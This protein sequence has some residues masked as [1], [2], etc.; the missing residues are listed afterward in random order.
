MDGIE[1]KIEGVLQRIPH[2]ISDPSSRR[3][4]E[5]VEWVYC[6]SQDLGAPAFAELFG[7]AV[8]GVAER[9]PRGSASTRQL[10]RNPITLCLMDENMPHPLFCESIG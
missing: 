3:D 1:Q 8:A 9:S 10:V 7:E 5:A 4:A 6:D 2:A